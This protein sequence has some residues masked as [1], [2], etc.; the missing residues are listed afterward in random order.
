MF[1]CVREIERDT[2]TLSAMTLSESGLSQSALSESALSWESGCEKPSRDK[3]GGGGRGSLCELEALE[4]AEELEDSDGLQHAD[5]A[6]VKGGQ[7]GE[8]WGRMQADRRR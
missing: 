5:L 6:G 8:A 3:Q 7:A 1:T 2:V 4:H